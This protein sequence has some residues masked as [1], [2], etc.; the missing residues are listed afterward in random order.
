MSSDLLYLKVNI[1]IMEIIDSFIYF[2]L[3][4]GPFGF[5]LCKSL[6]QYGKNTFTAFSDYSVLKLSSLCLFL[7]HLSVLYAY[8]IDWFCTTHGFR[9]PGP[10]ITQLLPGLGYSFICFS[11]AASNM[12]FNSPAEQRTEKKYVLSGVLLVILG[13]LYTL[14]HKL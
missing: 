14:N 7:V 10:V 13:Y 11:C 3:L 6:W 2:I 9:N 4:V 1:E 12:V 8:G 5:Y